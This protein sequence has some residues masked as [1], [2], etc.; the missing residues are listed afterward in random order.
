[1]DQ[2]NPE[3]SNSAETATDGLI[4]EVHPDPECA[5]SDGYQCLN[6]QQFEE[7]MTRCRRVAEA[8]D[9]TM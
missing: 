7:T 5:L 2:T 6:F 9:R 3:H 8:V 1:M 4:I